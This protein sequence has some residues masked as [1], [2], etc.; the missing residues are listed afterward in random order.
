MEGYLRY[1]KNISFDDISHWSQKEIDYLQ[2]DLGIPIASKEVILFRQ[3]LFKQLKKT[4]IKS[5]TRLPYQVVKI[6]KAP[7][8]WHRFNHWMS[9]IQT[10]PHSITIE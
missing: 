5:K 9:V 2:V 3:S 7:E 1:L 10:R 6:L 8:A 4:L